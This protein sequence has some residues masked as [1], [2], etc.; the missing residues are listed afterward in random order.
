MVT[1]KGLVDEGEGVAR[2]G[3]KQGIV[4]STD[5]S[6]ESGELLWDQLVCVLGLKGRL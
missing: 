5:G 3:K 2:S 4:I 1:T 6:I